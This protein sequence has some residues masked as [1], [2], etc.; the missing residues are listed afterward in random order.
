MMHVTAVDPPG[1]EEYRHSVR[2]LECD[3]TLPVFSAA[4]QDLIMIDLTIV[5][6][7]RLQGKHT[8]KTAERRNLDEAVKA[9]GGRFYYAW[10]ARH[11][12]DQQEGK[13]EHKKSLAETNE[14]SV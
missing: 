12:R 4:N 3:H 10:V 5:Y 11:K 13:E 6:E 2:T 8:F 9:R 7:S 1:S 14:K